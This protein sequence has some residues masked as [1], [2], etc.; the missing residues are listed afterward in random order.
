ML[1]CHDVAAAYE[2]LV[3]RGVEALA[4]PHVWL[5]RLLSA[6]LADPAGHPVQLVQDI[7]RPTG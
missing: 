1:W 4:E 7:A 6:W 5:D 3:G 2:E